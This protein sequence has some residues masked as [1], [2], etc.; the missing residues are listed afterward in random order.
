MLLFPLICRCVEDPEGQS[1]NVS[2]EKKVIIV[3]KDHRDGVD[4]VMRN[5]IIIISITTST[6]PVFYYVDLRLNH[7]VACL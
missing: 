4:A 3:S 1:H 5:I 6:A 7:T 2:F